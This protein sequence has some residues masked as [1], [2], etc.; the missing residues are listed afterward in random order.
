MGEEKNIRN[1]FKR[2]F[3]LFII[4]AVIIAVVYFLKLLGLINIPTL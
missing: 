1:R 4:I 2:D 3:G